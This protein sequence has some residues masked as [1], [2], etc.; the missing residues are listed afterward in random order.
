[1]RFCQLICIETDTWRSFLRSVRIPKR[2]ELGG[3]EEME[4]MAKFQVPNS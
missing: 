3:A 4:R 1:M 2:I